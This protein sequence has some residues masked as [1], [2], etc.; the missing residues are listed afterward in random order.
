M[1]VSEVLRYLTKC[2]FQE[3]PKHSDQSKS[4][5]NNQCKYPQLHWDV[6]AVL[7]L[8]PKK[9]SSC[10][11]SSARMGTEPF[12]REN[13]FSH[14]PLSHW[15]LLLY[16]AGRLKRQSKT[17]LYQLKARS[18]KGSKHLPTLR[19][20]TTPQGNELCP[21]P[22]HPAPQRKGICDMFW[23]PAAPSPDSLSSTAADVLCT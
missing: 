17:E 2:Y 15:Q 16:I 21:L 22:S 19:M 18:L 4:T 23:L 1:F 8:I 10:C 7:F 3:H 5:G 20:A 14:Q 9:N 6:G 11:P 12:V 13:T